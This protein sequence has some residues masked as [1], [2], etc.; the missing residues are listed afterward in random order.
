[1]AKER[2]PEEILEIRSRL[3]EIEFRCKSD[4]QFL[5]HLRD[6]PVRLL[7]EFGLDEDTTN[8]VMP[9]L[10]G[11]DRFASACGRCDPIT[12]W[13]TGCCFFTTEPPVDLPTA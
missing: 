7:R 1:V 12:C 4:D 3:V 8:Q 11:D 13:V 5:Q 10:V 6:E 9:Q 2:S